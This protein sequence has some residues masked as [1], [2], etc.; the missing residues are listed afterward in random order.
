MNQGES[1]A[2]IDESSHDHG[3]RYAWSNFRTGLAAGHSAVHLSDYKIPNSHRSAAIV[4]VNY[5]DDDINVDE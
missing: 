2:G 5:G 3:D 1:V 4:T